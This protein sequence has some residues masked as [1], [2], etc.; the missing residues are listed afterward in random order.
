MLEEAAIRSGA[1]S[2]LEAPLTL[3]PQAGAIV[4]IE[5]QGLSSVLI[6][7]GPYADVC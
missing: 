1:C 5:L 3:L 6:V 2:M 7:M 4:N